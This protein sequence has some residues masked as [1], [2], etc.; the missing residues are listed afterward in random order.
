MVTTV[1]RFRDRSTNISQW[2]K[3][4]SLKEKDIEAGMDS[5]ETSL[6]VLQFLNKTLI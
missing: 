5:S 1:S 6:Y 2:R 4:S 3:S